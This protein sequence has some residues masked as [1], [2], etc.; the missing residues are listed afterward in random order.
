[1]DL[2]GGRVVGSNKDMGV[3]VWIGIINNELVGPI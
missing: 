2:M 1:M 3:M